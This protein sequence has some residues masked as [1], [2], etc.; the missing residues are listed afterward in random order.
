VRA[1]VL[2]PKN[3]S[4]GST[5]AIGDEDDVTVLV[6]REVAMGTNC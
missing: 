4:V 1:P 2:V 3:H 6:T 5:S